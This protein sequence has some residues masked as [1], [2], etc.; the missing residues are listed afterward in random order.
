MEVRA[1]ELRD[2]RA[3]GESHAEAW[4]IGFSGLFPPDWLLGAVED[5]RQ[6]WCEALPG[7]LAEGS[8]MVAQSGAGVIGFVHFGQSEQEATVGEIFAL[9]VHPDHWGSGAAK[10]L[11][12]HASEQLGAEGIERVVLWTLAGAGRSRGFY[13]HNG[14]ALTG[15]TAMRDFGDGSPTELIQYWREL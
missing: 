11:S 14:W 10:A 3:I 15:R 6:R 8:V 12:Q 7:H 4:R 13:D 1:A 9:Y 5:R 2:A